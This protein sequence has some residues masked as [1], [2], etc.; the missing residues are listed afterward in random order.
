MM[1]MMS[2]NPSHKLHMNAAQTGSSSDKLS[3]TCILITTKISFTGLTVDKQ[4]IGK[5]VFGKCYSATMSSHIDVC[6]SF[7]V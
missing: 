6:Q 5:G 2:A 4:P 1:P 3:S 7:L